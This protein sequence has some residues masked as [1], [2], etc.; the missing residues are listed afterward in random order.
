MVHSL[1]ANVSLNWNLAVDG[2]IFADLVIVKSSIP[3]WYNFF[4]QI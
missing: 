1:L 3:S 4:W 2:E